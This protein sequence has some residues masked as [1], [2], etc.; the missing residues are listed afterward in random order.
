MYV[1][2]LL[3][4]PRGINSWRNP[5]PLEREPRFYCGTGGKVETVHASHARGRTPRRATTPP[6]RPTVEDGDDDD[7]EFADE[8]PK[9]PGEVDQ[10]PVIID[11]E[12]YINYSEQR[13][14]L[15]SNPEE[16][17]TER[18]GRSERQGKRS[19]EPAHRGLQA[20]GIPDAALS[21]PPPRPT[22]PTVTDAETL[23]AGIAAAADG[24]RR[25]PSTHRRRRRSPADLPRI[26]TDMYGPRGENSR[27]SRSQ[28][29]V[30]TYE[31]D[32]RY[33][34]PRSPD[35]PSRLARDDYL[36]PEVIKS[37][38]ITEEESYYSN[39]RW[40]RTS[41]YSERPS[42]SSGRRHDE[43]YY[44]TG[45]IETPVTVSRT[46]LEPEPRNARVSRRGSPRARDEPVI[47]PE[48]GLEGL[49]AFY[50]DPSRGAGSPPRRRD[51]RSRRYTNQYSGDES[52]TSSIRRPGRRPIVTQADDR[53]SNT[54]TPD[55]ARYAESRPRPKT[56]TVSSR[57]NGYRDNGPRGPRS[58]N[59]SAQKIDSASVM[60]PYPVEDMMPSQDRPGYLELD[61]WGP[62]SGPR[63]THGPTAMPIQIPAPSGPRDSR[64]GSRGQGTSRSWQSSPP[65][66]RG[67][68]QDSVST[69]GYLPPGPGQPDITVRRY[70]EDPR[71]L[72]L[73][74]VPKCPRKIPVA[75]MT[76]W[77]TLA[78][79]DNRFTICPTCY[80]EVFAKSPEFRP[81]FKPLLPQDPDKKVRCDFGSSPWYVVAWLRSLK[82]GFRDHRLLLEVSR[83]TSDHAKSGE[84]CPG[85]RKDLRL[86][87]SVCNPAT[88]RALPDFNVCRECARIVAALMPNLKEVL[89]NRGVD[90]YGKC[91]LRCGSD[92]G[93]F[94]LNFDA[95][96][97]ASD[98]AVAEGKPVS[99]WRLVEDI[100]A[101]SQPLICPRDNPVRDARWYTMQWLP[102]LTVCAACY[103]DAACPA[104]KENPRSAE[105][106]RMGVVRLR[107]GTCQL[108]SERMRDVF[109]EAC[110]RNDTG[111]LE[112]AVLER[113]KDEEE[114]KGAMHR[115][116]RIDDPFAMAEMER[117]QAKWRKLE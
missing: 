68:W 17:A 43:A 110:R 87:H 58:P 25:R 101:V 80:G 88:G 111:L 90:G 32:Y 65:K 117:L 106:F 47:V 69:T 71:R 48:P 14:V 33:K 91:S 21:T 57:Q 82:N 46:K 79:D 107:Y 40:P 114:V 73:P 45:Y 16:K 30:P 109:R 50:P 95:L 44:N 60:P 81:Y 11:N 18:N 75:G 113:L 1:A 20:D 72:D 93:E 102:E 34:V 3:T 29:S 51:P 103:E 115:L 10:Q 38:R 112:D 89:M 84:D 2:P 35:R 36:S 27:Y 7:D 6:P 94:L 55:D 23:G 105:K 37:G 53:S 67:I 8:Q 42:S 63:G 24:T 64:P 100:A 92:R 19:G 49:S 108:Y 99:E 15:V 66:P 13:F 31:T 97:R 76:D 78:D 41:R 62:S 54:I 26:D 56:T 9:F 59:S 70:Y 22:T 5:E 28:S 61:Y 39:A 116:G 4:T 52:D 74:K 12:N 98:E 83:I 86:W 96:E 85:G 104:L 77:L